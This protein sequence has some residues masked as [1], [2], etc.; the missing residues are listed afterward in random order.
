[1]DA[2]IPLHIVCP[3]T[4]QVM[5]DPCVASDG[6]SYEKAALEQHIQSSK[7]RG[8]D[9]VSPRTGEPIQDLGVPNHLLRHHIDKWKR[10]AWLICKLH[11][12]AA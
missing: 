6:W 5:H 10:R 3:L 7:S 11:A 8:V 4:N 2:F 12:A 9:A 1:M